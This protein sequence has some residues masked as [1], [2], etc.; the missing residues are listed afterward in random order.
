V[1]FGLRFGNVRASAFTCDEAGIRLDVGGDR[2]RSPL[3]GILNVYNLLAAYC[4]TRNILDSGRVA[5][6]AL[7]SGQPVPG[8]LERISQGC[9]IEVYVDY[10]HTAESVEAVLG[11]IRRLHPGRR[12]VA[13]IG[14][15][16]N[17]DKTKRAPIARAAARFADACVFT[18]DNPGEEHA[19]T[20]LMS[21]LRGLHGLSTHVV[22]LVDRA[23]AIRR[24]IETALPGGV[25][26]LMGKGDET[27]QLIH[28]EHHAHSDREIASAI[29]AE[30]QGSQHPPESGEPT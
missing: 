14:C 23:Q 22:T 1:S 20:I 4:I 5:A 18:S 17:S 12:L 9:G 7:S 21:M 27:Y 15:S 8:R 26:A 29:L 2:I 13:L 3:L 25:V 10:A 19:A 28:G 30:L 11:A 24:A 6:E 16:G